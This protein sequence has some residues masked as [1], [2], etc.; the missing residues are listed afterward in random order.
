LS[1]KLATY[2]NAEIKPFLSKTYHKIF[3]KCI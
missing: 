1:T 3:N 2:G